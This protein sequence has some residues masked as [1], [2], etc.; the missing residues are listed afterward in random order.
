MENNFDKEN[1]QLDT[2]TEPNEAPTT[3]ASVEEG[4]VEEVTVEEENVVPESEE[5]K[6]APTSDATDS[7]LPPAKKTFPAW[8][9]GVLGVLLVSV[10]ALVILII[11][12]NVDYTVTVIDEIGNPVSNVMVKLTDATGET[13]TRVTDKSGKAIFKEIKVK[14]IGNNNTV[15][16]DKGM[17]NAKIL[18]A[19]YQLD[20][21]STELRAVVCDESKTQNIT[22][23]ID[24]G[25]YAYN[26]VVGTYNIPA[27]AGKTTY[28][29]FTSN[30]S[31]TYKISFSSDDTEMTVGHYGIP[32]YV[33]SVHTL[34]GEYD[35]K[36]F[37]FIIQDVATPHVIGLNCVNTA[38]A[39][40]T[41]ERIGDAPFDPSY[42][43]WTDVKAPD[44]LT[45][46]DTSGKTLES[47]DIESLT[48]SVSRG[49]D[50]YYYTNDGKKVYARITSSNEKYGNYVDGKFAPL[51][52]SLAYLAGYVN[53]HV[54]MN[55]GGYIYDD[56]GNFVCKK[57][58]NGL[59][60]TYM[61]YVDDNYGV[62]PLTDD[63][64]DCIKLFGESCQWWKTGSNGYIFDG[65]PV[66][67][68][69]AWLIFC[70]AEK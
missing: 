69:N 46:C 3:E 32:M 49:N 29:I 13:K 35:G 2:A 19:E 41:I 10:I 54:G 65:I 28:L 57:L 8:I 20:K 53:E 56:E 37:E 62:V 70:M 11:P 39:V 6:T 7:V 26:A 47:I 59:I 68:E 25:N 42:V 58:Y 34:E 14:K 63:L 9:L 36:S 18:T 15:K 43:A 27:T 48:L 51:V 12:K 64:V 40:L 21:K 5:T 24:D 1:E 31:G 67:V 33:Q 55:V 66:N 17:S 22:G 30:I 16:L 45:K 50:G 44:N 61:D 4:N 23:L 52:E 60:K 38:D